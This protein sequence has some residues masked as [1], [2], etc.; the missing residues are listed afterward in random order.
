ML[1]L[2]VAFCFCC[3]SALAQE[4]PALGLELKGGAVVGLTNRLTGETYTWP[5]DGADA[6]SALRLCETGGRLRELRDGEEGATLTAAV[7]ADG[8]DLVVEQ[9]GSRDGG[10]VSGTWLGLGPVDASKVTLLVP[11]TGGVSLGPD[12]AV[13]DV[14]YHYPGA[15]GT[16]AV[17]LQGAGGGVLVSADD[18][19]T[20]FAALRV[21]R[22]QTTWRV[23]LLTFVDPPWEARTQARS[24]R[25]R[26]SAFRGP[27]TTAAAV[28]R[29]RIQRAFDLTSRRDR[30]PKWADDIQCMVRVVGAGPAEE[31]LRALAKAIEPSRTLLYLPDWRTNPYDVMYPDY[32]PSPKAV[33]FIR[34]AHELGF[35]VMAHGNLVGISPFHPRVEEFRDALER[36]A[37]THDPVGWYLDRDVPGQIFCLNPAFAKVRKLLVDALVASHGQ[38]GFDALHLDFPLIVLSHTG[39]VEGRNP[40]QGTVALLRELQ[41]AMPEVPLGTEGISDFMLACSWAQ[42][43]EPFWNNDERMGRYHPV[44]AAMFSDFCHVYGHLGLPDQQTDLQAYLSFL[45]VHDRTGS[46]PTFSLNLDQSFAP[47]SPGTLY[48]LRQA[49]FFLER[50]PVPDYETVLQ[51]V[52]APGDQ[53]AVPYFAW[54]LAG[55]G[56]LA[57]V[58]T[59]G[60]R[61]WIAREPG[62]DWR[63]LW[64]VYQGVTEI[65]GDF[66]V[67]GW[68]AYSPGR[69][70]GLDPKAIYLPETGAP[71]AGAFH[72]TSASTPVRVT[73]CGAEARRDLMCL[74]PLLSD[75]LRLTDVRPDRT[76]L[77]V[78]GEEL[79]PGNGSSF[80]VESLVAGGVA[81]KGILAHPPWQFPAMQRGEFSPAFRP[82]AFGEYRVVLPD[83]DGLRFRTRLGLGDLPTPGT[84]SGDG[85]TFCVLVDGKEVLRRD[86]ARRA[87]EPVDVDLNPWRGREIRL[88][89][90]TDVGPA[91]RPDFDWACWGEPTVSL[92]DE[93]APTTLEF[94]QPNADGALVV[95]DRNGTRTFDAKRPSVDVLLPASVLYVRGAEEVAGPVALTAL[96]LQTCLVSGGVLTP[97]SVYGAGTPAQWT[98]GPQALPALNGHT[99]AWGQTHLEWLLHLPSQLLRLAVG[100]GIRKGGEQVAFRILVNGLVV[101]DGGDPGSGRM[102][103]GSVD[104]SPWAG[105]PVLLSLVTDSLGSNNCDW[106]VWVDPRLERVAP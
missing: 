103:T 50:R 24:A 13:S 19:G 17:I 64:R 11:G 49:R 26:F 12:S 28:Q 40:L 69:F 84:P 73:L 74:E 10:G 106:A 91:G 96:K 34:L 27:W 85:V 80:S 72:L 16:P 93:A 6:G 87:W 1:I 71:D 8:S 90:V 57:V 32:T 60:G 55:G 77:L 59:S 14:T 29:D 41:A 75:V 101:W 53:P 105:Q 51:P 76:G 79:P 104:L 66:H 89:L 95:S 39:P 30:K 92:G 54:R 15:W 3:R 100:A 46:L 37:A 4:T 62:A 86:H 42:L 35:R 70:F 82:A 38:A 97:G 31:P 56:N 7:R 65:T 5:A 52:A 94:S 98:D 9:V 22:L 67:R 88:R 99:P 36:D 18:P 21:T 33:A 25:W 63:E 23:A 48:A 83:A 2:A 78:N 58:Q 102:V 81:L 44:R 43:G 20:S 47:D 68:L 45:E 61:K